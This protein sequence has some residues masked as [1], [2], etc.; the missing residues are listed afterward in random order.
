MQNATEEDSSNLG[1]RISRSVLEVFNSLK[2]KAAKPVLRSNGVKEWTVLAGVVAINISND[3]LKTICIATGVKALPNEVRKTSNGLVVH[4]LHAEVLCLRLFNWFLLDEC[5]KLKTDSK[6]SSEI[7]HITDQLEFKL[8]SNVRLAL[9]VTEP[10]CGDASMGRMSRELLDST[11]WEL[12]ARK[13]QKLS[14][15]GS[16]LRGRS[17]LDQLGIVRTKPGRSD[18]VITLSKSCSDKLCIKQLVGITNS[19]TSLLF[20]ENIFLDYLVLPESK[21][22]RSDF[23]RCFKER[24]SD[25]LS[26][27]CHSLKALTYNG[28]EYKYNKPIKDGSSVASPLSLLYIFPTKTLQILNNGVKNG[29]YRKSKVP[30]IGDESIICNR[31]LF[32]KFKQLRPEKLESY[33]DLKL[34]N[35]KRQRLKEEARQVLGNWQPTDI[36]NFNLN[37]K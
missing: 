25:K 23:D 9:Y 13:R 11:P 1:E 34:S 37:Y 20:P 30:G 28:K 32:Q 35:P 29:C 6:C 24:F 4:D 21:Y 10:P 2:N 7:L 31:Q 15:N 18:S 5:L 22:D 16:I 33:V 26:C 14:S 36:D 17:H 12:D 19:F 3:N 8:N 27:S